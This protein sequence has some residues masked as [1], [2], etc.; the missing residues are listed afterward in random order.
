[1]GSMGSM[2]SMGALSSILGSSMAPQS[3]SGLS[4]A[5]IVDALSP[6]SKHFAHLRSSEGS[7]SELSDSEE[8]LDAGD[9]EMTSLRQKL[10]ALQQE[11]V[12]E[13]NWIE[14]VRSIVAHYR[15]K[16]LNVQASLKQQAIHAHRLK[17]LIAAQHKVLAKQRLQHQLD[18]VVRAMLLLQNQA[19]HVSGK[20][21]T[22]EAMKHELQAN[23]NQ[24]QKQLTGLHQEQ[25]NGVAG[26]GSCASESSC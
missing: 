24:I 15:A 11:M 23:I 8:S 17:G 12:K 22:L 26:E 10:T 16:V 13:R 2:S 18:K 20:K 14:A 21:E 25:G 1:M 3:S 5:Q 19:Q 9:P 7:D 6:G 4:P